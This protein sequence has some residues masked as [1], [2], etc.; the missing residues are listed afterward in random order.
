MLR[1]DVLNKIILFVQ[2]DFSHSVKQKGAIN[3]VEGI[4]LI[5]VGLICIFLQ[6]TQWHKDYIEK[7]N[8]TDTEEL[9]VFIRNVFGACFIFIG[10]LK[11]I[12]TLIS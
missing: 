2:T 4:I 3:M 8:F 1:N 12:I 11:C 10:V 5:F 6:R 9:L 7:H